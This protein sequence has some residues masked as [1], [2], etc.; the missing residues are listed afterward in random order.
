MLID[1][2]FFLRHLFKKILYRKRVRPIYFQSVDKNQ[3][4]FIV[5]IMDSTGFGIKILHSSAIFS[6]T[7]K[8]SP[9][10]IRK[11]YFFRSNNI[12]SCGFFSFFIITFCIDFTRTKK[13][14]VMV[15]DDDICNRKIESNAKSQT[16]KRNRNYKKK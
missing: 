13:K 6:R 11:Q 16:M 14:Y 8:S 9:T 12:S 4:R 10:K 1:F 15:N 2:Q 5:V 3:T 7:T